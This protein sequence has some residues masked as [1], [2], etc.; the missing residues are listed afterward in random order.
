MIVTNPLFNQL[1]KLVCFLNKEVCLSVCRHVGH[2][3]I[4]LV[5]LATA[6]LEVGGETDDRTSQ[7]NFQCLK[8]RLMMP[9]PGD[10]VALAGDDDPGELKHRIVGCGETAVS[11]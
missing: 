5:P 10:T 4:H 7:P 9:Q 1:L 2:I 6:P 11:G 3:V 8:G